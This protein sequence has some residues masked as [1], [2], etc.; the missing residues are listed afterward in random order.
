MIKIVKYAIK[1]NRKKQNYTSKQ[2]NHS[3]FLLASSSCRLPVLFRRFPSPTRYPCHGHHSSPPQM[4]SRSGNTKAIRTRR[5]LNPSS[6]RNIL[7][8]SSRF[9]PLYNFLPHSSILYIL[10]YTK[11]GP[12]CQFFSFFSS[13]V[14]LPRSLRPHSLSPLLLCSSW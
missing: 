4:V 9:S 14:A 7:F 11:S 3:L 10:L 6:K 8:W 12:T 5:I 13:L 2:Q 1:S